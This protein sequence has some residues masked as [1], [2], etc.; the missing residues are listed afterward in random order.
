VVRRKGV[1]KVHWQLRGANQ[2]GSW[3]FLCSFDTVAQFAMEDNALVAEVKKLQL[4]GGCS[5]GSC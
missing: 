3:H 5:S 2:A 4:V 1:F